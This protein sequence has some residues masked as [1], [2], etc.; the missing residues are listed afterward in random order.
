MCFSGLSLMSQPPQLMSEKGSGGGL[1]LSRGTYTKNTHNQK[2]SVDNSDQV[3]N[4]KHYTGWSLVVSHWNNNK[5]WIS[6]LNSIIYL[7]PGSQCFISPVAKP[8]PATD[9]W[10]P[11]LLFGEAGREV[12]CILPPLKAGASCTFFLR[13]HKRWGGGLSHQ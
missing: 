7:G 1:A 8:S 6:I 2:D 9:T 12:H 3:S 13:G 5:V 11:L 4:M 10:I